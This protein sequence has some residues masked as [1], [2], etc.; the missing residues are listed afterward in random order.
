MDLAVD[1][2]DGAEHDRLCELQ[3]TVSLPQFQDGLPPFDT[4]GFI[5]TLQGVPAKMRDEQAPVVL[6]LPHAPM[7]EDG[8]PVV[9]FLLLSGVMQEDP[10][11]EH[12]RVMDI[13]LLPKAEVV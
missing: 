8:Y 5:D 6:T 3:G 2:F 4:G 12:T 1:P 9:V 13:D 11:E 10:L 7:P